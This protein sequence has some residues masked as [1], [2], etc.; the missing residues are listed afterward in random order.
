M[1]GFK[2]FLNEIHKRNEVEVSSLKELVFENVVC[3]TLKEIKGVLAL[4]SITHMGSAQ[5]LRCV[6]VRGVLTSPRARR[7]RRPAPP[8]LASARH[9]TSRH[10]TGRVRSGRR[11]IWANVSASRVREATWV[12]NF[13]SVLI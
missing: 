6:M 13:I 7:R 11:A 2:N 12:G 5:L 4:Y 1:Y 3:P 9:V 10:D 8:R